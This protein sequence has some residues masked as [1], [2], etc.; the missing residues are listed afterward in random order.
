LKLRF[1]AAALLLLLAAPPRADVIS[2][3]QQD[4]RRLKRELSRKERERQDADRKTAELEQEV[5]RI[6]REMRSSKRALK[7][8]EDRLRENDKRRADAEDRLWASRL[9]LRQWNGMLSAELKR[10]YERRLTA[11]AARFTE[12]AWRRALVRDRISGVTEALR[13]HEEIKSAH[14]DLVSA[15]EEF[16][17]LH[18]RR[19]AEAARVAEA[20]K[21]MTGLLDTAKGRRAVLENDIRELNASAQKFEK[22][23][24][25]LIRERQ[26]REAQAKAAA[27]RE[28]QVRAKSAGRKSARAAA[29]EKGP[30]DFGKL[31]WP[32]EGAVVERFGKFKHPELETVVVSNGIKIRPAHP[33]PVRSVAPGEVLYAGEFMG[34][35]LMALVSHPDS[36]FTIYAHLGELKVKKGQKV[37]VG[38]IL[39]A[40]GVDAEDRPVVYFELRLHGEAMDPLLWL[41]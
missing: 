6:S 4:L 34:Y 19:E 14:E 1:A 15:R 9:D 37:S 23:I 36:L 5:D 10:L 27:E 12:I 18:R 31:P 8:V 32:A 11:D 13:R 7:D 33:G 41:R 30:A 17:G 25:D 20:R 28:R 24:M 40:S 21:S 35:G 16:E 39:G 38:E 26:E 3:R 29:P 2:S 22:L